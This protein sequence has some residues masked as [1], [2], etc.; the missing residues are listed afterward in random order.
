[1]KMEPKKIVF[2]ITGLS[3]G[4]AETQLVRLATRLKARGWDI[5]VVSM[6]PPKAYVEEL[7]KAGIPVYSLNMRRGV[8]DPRAIFRLARIIRKFRPHILHSHMVHA[9]ILARMVRPLALVPVLI[10]TVHS[11]DER[12]KKGSRR[13]RILAYRFTDFLCNLTTQ[14]AQAG[15]KWYVQIK[16]VPKHKIRYIPNGVNTEQFRHDPEA[17]AHLRKELGIGDDF[18]WIAV[19]RFD[20][21]KDYPNMLQAFAQV[22]KKNPKVRLFVV[23][24]GPLRLEMESL[25]KG[26]RIDANVKF[27]GIR[28]DV[29]EL[30]NASD[31]FVMSSAWEGM[32]NVLLE[33]ASSRLPIVATDVG[34]NG[35]I[36]LQGKT[37]F[38]V[39]PKN[40][41]AL[42]SA[43]L[44]LMNLTPEERQRMGEKGRK[45]IEEKYSLEKVVEK[46]EELY[47]ELLDKSK[48]LSFT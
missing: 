28:Q 7:E 18:V 12:G 25:A 45:H 48:R 41:E 6:L 13:W 2:L 11:I 44:K 15:L 17:R 35:E 19:G 40:P 46:W 32:P 36:V 9:N 21:P 16:A 43:M 24:D 37:G 38:H 5:I 26:L 39:P 14:V 3:Y 1:M 33:A 29:P 8:P 47:M 27:L 22:W 34:G 31:A 23:G 42:T 20:P 30:L 4:G 10:C